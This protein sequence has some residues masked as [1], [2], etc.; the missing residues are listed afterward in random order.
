MKF[1]LVEIFTEFLSKKCIK[2]LFPSIIPF[3][4]RA[5]GRQAFVVKMPRG[6]ASLVETLVLSLGLI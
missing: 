2:L 6:R 1:F 5:S 4:T 3:I